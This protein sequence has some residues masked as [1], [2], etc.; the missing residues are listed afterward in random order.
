LSFTVNLKTKHGWRE[1]REKLFCKHRLGFWGY[2][3]DGE[4]QLSRELLEI[5]K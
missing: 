2:A 4:K 5:K 1:G 3:F